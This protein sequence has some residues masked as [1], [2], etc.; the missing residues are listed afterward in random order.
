[1]RQPFRFRIRT[2]LIAVVL[3]AILLTIG[4]RLWWRWKVDSALEATVAIG[5][6]LLLGI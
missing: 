5:P 6:E 2:L 4:P 3:V 1:M